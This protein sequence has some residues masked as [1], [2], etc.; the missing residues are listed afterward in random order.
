MLDD[1]HN[2]GLGSAPSLRRGSQGPTY[3][4]RKVLLY[5][6]G[7][8]SYNKFNERVSPWLMS[9]FARDEEIAGVARVLW[10]ELQCR[11]TDIPCEPT[12]ET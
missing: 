8:F 2:A 12:A 11:R 4:L 7:G 1:K 9:E 5:E 3:Q 6:I 10:D